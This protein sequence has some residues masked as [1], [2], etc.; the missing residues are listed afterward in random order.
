MLFEKTLHSRILREVNERGLLRD[1]QFEF[2]PRLST[3]LLLDRLVETVTRN[4]EGDR[5]S[6]A[7]FLD[8]AKALTPYMSKVSFTILLFYTS[9]IT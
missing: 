9:R 1:K 2:R 7:A 6:G 8:V 3:K 4:R 5:L